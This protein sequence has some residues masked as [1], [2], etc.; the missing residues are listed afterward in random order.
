MGR[1]WRCASPFAVSV[2]AGWATR[3][4]CGAKT[5]RPSQP[6][7][8]GTPKGRETRWPNISANWGVATTRVAATLQS[9]PLTPPSESARLSG[10][11]RLGMACT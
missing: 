10:L 5:T 3:R 2:V 6:L 9:R 7:A 11:A 8:S 4:V 1:S